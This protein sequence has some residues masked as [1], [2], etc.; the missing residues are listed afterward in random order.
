MKTETIKAP[1]NC[2]ECEAITYYHAEKKVIFA[3]VCHKCGWTR[4][5]KPVKK[6][7]S[8]IACIIG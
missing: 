6:D 1:R 7:N 8:K 3:E 2:P 5:I 4:N